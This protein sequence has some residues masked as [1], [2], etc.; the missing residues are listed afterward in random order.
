MSADNPP[1]LILH[2]TRDALVPLAQSEEFADA[3]KK[4]G[5][6]VT[7]QKF[8]G[9]GHGGPAFRLPAVQK[10]IH[11]F[12]D[13]NLKGMDVKVEALPETE[14]MP[15]PATMPGRPATMPTRN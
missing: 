1:I 8:P 10:L 7:L 5:V 14:V 2:G 6:D 4:A 15:P 11:N 12:F 3:L 13:K 9:S